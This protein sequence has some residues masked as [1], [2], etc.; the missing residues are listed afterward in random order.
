MV[1]LG[2]NSLKGW[3]LLES[4]LPNEFRFFF[5]LKYPFV[6]AEV[7]QVRNHIVIVV[8][9]CIVINYDGLG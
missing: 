6:V 1:G 4:I 7:A 5:G 9:I 2:G 3:Y 8:L